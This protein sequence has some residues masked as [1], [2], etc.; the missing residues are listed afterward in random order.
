[1]AGRHIARYTPPWVY[2]TLRYVRPLPPCI[3]TTLVYT[4]R[5]HRKDTH[6]YTPGYIGGIPTVIHLSGTMGG[7]TP[8]LYTSRVPWRAY[9][10][11]IHLSGTM[12]G[13]L[14]PSVI[15][16]SGTM[17]GILPSVIHLSGTMGGYPD[18]QS[19]PPSLG[20]C[21]QCCAECPSF[22]G[23]KR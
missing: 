1:M 18:A 2:P 14:P 10:T 22:F 16:L 9:T 19:G 7:Y 17:V 21:G 15:H 8:L 3:Y 12:A 6:H 4:T 11:V 20:E 23:L 13:Y 5:V